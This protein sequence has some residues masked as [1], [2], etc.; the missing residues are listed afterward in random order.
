MAINKWAVLVWH[1]DTMANSPGRVMWFHTLSATVNAD[2]ARFRVDGFFFKRQLVKAVLLGAIA[3]LVAVVPSAEA[4]V[5]IGLIL[6]GIFAIF[7][8][9]IKALKKRGAK[10]P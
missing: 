8:L 3:W 10:S 5:G 4:F 6:L 7:D 1:A 2:N 9:S